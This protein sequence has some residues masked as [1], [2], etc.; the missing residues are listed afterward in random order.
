LLVKV[1]CP[2]HNVLTQLIGLDLVTK[3][4]VFTALH[5]MQRQSSNENSVRPPVCQTRAL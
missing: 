4:T 5:A 3:V 1:H 2:G